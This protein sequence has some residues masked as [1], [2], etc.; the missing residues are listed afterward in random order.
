MAIKF[1]DNLDLNGN[2]LLKAKLQVLAGDP[3]GV[4]IL[5]EG[6]IFFD[7][8]AGVKAFK[9]Y[10]GTDWIDPSDG[11]FTSWT[12]EGDSGAS[13]VITDGNTLE[14]NGLNG[15]TTKGV[16][17]DTLQVTLD[18]TAV[19]AG[20]YTLANITVDAQGRITSAANGSS[21]SMSTWNMKGDNAV[22]RIIADGNTITFAGGTGI[23]TTSSNPASGI[24]LL[25]AGLDNTAVTAGSYTTANI[26]VDAQGRITAASTGSSAVTYTLPVGSGSNLAT[27]TLTGSDT[28]T[29]VVT[30][31]GTANETTVV[32]NNAASLTIGLPDDV[33]IADD[34]TVAGELTVQGT[35]QSSFAG[36][37]TGITPTA[38]GDLAT[39]GYV[40]TSVAG[41]LNVKGGFNANTGVTAVAGTNLYTNTALAI[42]DYYVVTVAG[43][44][45]GDKPGTTS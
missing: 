17:T 13:Q 39:K 30:I 25:G 35:G 36:K 14:I 6:Q 26:T 44:F 1:L 20:S 34:L 21:G 10:N 23:T 29:D 8:S 2:Q 18:S 31:N 24:F 42:G 41:G 16:A 4:A 37:V 27:L 43:N 28:S 33:T 15:I 7:S 5:G 40:D 3:S 22:N 38:A 45:F 32:A 19:T 9:Y 11:S 12:V